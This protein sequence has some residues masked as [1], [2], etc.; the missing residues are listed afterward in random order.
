MSADDPLSGPGPLAAVAAGAGSSAFTATD[1][2]KTDV[3]DQRKADAAP[4]SPP[5]PA[6]L[7]TALSDAVVVV[8]AAERVTYWSQGATALYGRPAEDMLGRPLSDA[9]TYGWPTPDD[10]ACALAALE[11]HGEWTGDVVHHLRSGE[12][13][14]L[15]VTVN[16]VTN[17]SN[18][19]FTIAVMR[20]VTARK[21][22][23]RE[24]ER[25]IT[26]Y[27]LIEAATGLVTW[28][29]DWTKGEAFRTGDFAAFA[30][31]DESDPAFIERW[32][33]NVDARDRERTASALRSVQPGETVRVEYRYHH[34]TR[35]VRW[36]RTVAG[37]PAAGDSVSAL[38]GIALDITE[39]KKAQEERER[40]LQSE[41]IAHAVADAA[42]HH[43]DVFIATAAHELRSPLSV[44]SGWAAM[45]RSHM[46]Q[47]STN[48]IKALNGLDRSI[49]TAARLVEELLDHS[50]IA[51]GTLRLDRKPLDLQESVR[52]VVE[53]FE[54]LANRRN[55]QLTSDLASPAVALADGGRLSQVLAN[56]LS[57]ALKF[58]PAGGS[59]TV[60]LTCSGTA[61]E[62]RVTDTGQGIE[63]DKLPRLF[64]PFF[65][66]SPAV[67]RSGGLGLG[68]SISRTLVAMHGGTLTV[69]SA[70]L[71]KGTTCTVT[72]PLAQS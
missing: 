27:H 61:A 40:L 45:L 2:Q 46:T 52:H 26:T 9:Y 51:A 72:L 6:D 66:S 21:V 8:D 28:Q 4:W 1:V 43:R 58:T 16:R 44:M 67:K 25:R 42:L 59:V 56:L 33:E 47:G 3:P 30:G 60:N 5:A 20:D 10:E 38:Y 23:E 55:I 22:A 14:Y 11:R 7:F 49:Q 29:V 35:G 24:L 54:L 19:Q 36:M 39:E 32:W 13:K 18:E 50:R 12:Q 31:I 37:R 63:P 62:I 15:N 64:E 57:N 69:E 65:Q 71:G 48:V 41:Q 68:L 17:A 34:P 70:G 53:G